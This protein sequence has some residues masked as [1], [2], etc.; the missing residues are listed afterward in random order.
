MTKEAGRRVAQVLGFNL[1]WAVIFFGASGRLDHTRAWIYLGAGLVLLILNAAVV[2]R[3]NPEVIAARSRLHGGTK[4]FD[5]V[6]GALYAAVVL[7]TPV[8]AGLDVR[9]SWAP[10]SQAALWPGLL[11]LFLGN[12][13]ILASLAENP[14]LEQTVRIQNDRGHRVITT[15]PYRLVRHPMYIGVILQHLAVPLAIGSALALAPAAAA[16]PLLVVRTALEDRALRRELP[17]Y[18]AYARRTRYRLVPGFW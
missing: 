4:T 8:V 10:L 15:G 16:V 1:V 2:A 11:L 12:I 9:Y 18:E 14:H 13:P 7:A 6:F 3:K 17:G 5:K